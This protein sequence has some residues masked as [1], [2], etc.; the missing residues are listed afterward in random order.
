MSD[1]VNS[2]AMHQGRLAALRYRDFRLLAEPV[3]FEYRHLDAD[4]SH[5]LVA[6]STDQLTG[7]T[8]IER[9]LSRDPG[10]YARLDQRNLR[11]SLRSSPA[12]ARDTADSR[13]AEFRPRHP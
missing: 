4:D 5:Q 11:G 1:T 3:Y 10:D 8:R 2:A 6:L 12:D 7:A 9:H 13:C